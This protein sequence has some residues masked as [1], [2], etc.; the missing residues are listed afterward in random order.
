MTDETTPAQEAGD[1]VVQP[2]AIEAEAAEAPESTEGQDEA[3]PAEDESPETPGAESEDQ[4]SKSQERRERRKA[5]LDRIRQSQIEAEKEAKDAQ[6]R[7]KA[8]QEASTKLSEPKQGDFPDFDKYQAA[9]SAYYMMRG[10]D[11]REAAKLESEAKARFEKVQQAK[12]EQAQEAAQNWAAQIE[13]AKQRYPDFDQ[14]ARNPTLPISKALGEQITAS[15]VAGDLAYYLGKNPEQAARLSSLPPV[16]MA[17][18]IGRIE[19]QVSAPQPKTVSTAPQPISPVKPK[20]TPV[21]D[22]SKMSYAD[23]VAARKSGKLR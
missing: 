4:K 9:L 12:Q 15:D 3:Q 11:G 14:V 1:E 6:E 21:L 23:F 17:R 19:Q 22:P 8:Y 5:E 2:N 18:A 16:E 20:A 10:F 13:E 7:L